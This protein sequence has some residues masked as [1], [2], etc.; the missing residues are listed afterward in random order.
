VDRPVRLP[1]PPT[2]GPPEPGPASPAAP[3]SESHDV[4]RSALL[5]VALA[6]TTPAPAPVPEPP[7]PELVPAAPVASA[8]VRHHRPLRAPVVELFHLDH[9]P[10]G[11]GNRG[12]EYAP[13]AGT[14]VR[15]TAAGT[16]SFAGTVAGQRYVSVQHADGIRS[17]YS[18]LAT[19]AVAAGQ[20]VSG[21][22]VVG[23]T[24]TTF[25]IGFRRGDTYLDPAGLFGPQVARLVPDDRFGG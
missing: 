23:T 17:T 4:L 1:S 24:G 3:L 15:A 25:Q 9:G 16:V 5:L 20:V 2:H 6:V 8:A 22:Q 7:P 18:Y 14:A 12:W 19:V 21:G 13:T 11:A 10:Y